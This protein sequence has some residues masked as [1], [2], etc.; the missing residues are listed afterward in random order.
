MLHNF[1]KIAL[2]Q[3]VKNKIYSIT[4][5]TGLT[6]GITF[7]LLVFMVV[8]FE[9][10][11]DGYHKNR[12]CIYRVNTGKPGNVLGKGSQTGLMPALIDEFPEIKKVAVARILHSRVGTQLE[13]N[14]NLSLEK[15]AFFVT[16]SFY[17]MFDATWIAGSPATSLA[18]PG[19]VV[20]TESLA[21][22]YF[23]GQ[24]IDNMIKIDNEYEV[25][26]SGI[27]K[28]PPLN[29]DFPI[30]IAISHATFEQSKHFE[31]GDFNSTYSGYQTYVMLGPENTPE[32]LEA[33]FPAMITKYLGKEA[34]QRFAYALQPLRDIHFN[35]AIGNFNRRTTSRLTL[36]IMALI[37]VLILCI[38]SF[39]FINLSTAQAINRATEVGVRKVMGSTRS[40]LMKQFFSET[41]TFVMAAAGLSL[42]ALSILIPKL[43]DII[44]LPGNALQLYFPDMLLVL[45]MIVVLLTFLSGL[46]PALIMANLRPISTL[47]KK[48]G[49]TTLKAGSLRRG[50]V[51]FQFTVTMIMIISTVVVLFQTHYVLRKPLGF[52]KEAVIALDLPPHAPK[53]EAALR[54]NLLS[55][56]SIRDI[57]FSL[58]TPSATYNR[59]FVHYGHITFEEGIMAELK[60]I[61]TNYLAM[62][63]IQILAGRNLKA[64]DPNSAIL[65][66]ETLMKQIGFN[67][68]NEV[69]GESIEFIGIKGE[70]VGVVQNFHSL[71]LKTAIYPLIFF[72]D[73]SWFHKA[74][75]KIDMAQLASILSLIKQQWHDFFPKTFFQYKFL[76]EDIAS[77]YRQEIKTS[78]LLSLL[79]GVAIFIACLGLFGLAAYDAVQ[80]TKEIGIRKVMGASVHAILFLLSKNYL[81]LILVAFLIAIPVTNYLVS[82]WLQEFAY[83][84][85]LNLWIFVA[86][87]LFVAVTAWLAILGQSFQAAVKNPSETLKYE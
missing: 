48:V 23:D 43:I 35:I 72:R 84:I 45:A 67:D 33:K 69:L 18:N 55:H 76:D 17:E 56:S 27:I 12:D 24:A 86:P 53:V 20:I 2:R 1:L 39:N 77:F 7:A 10:S 57:S 37:G 26:V 63:D 78:R 79:A 58:N 46:Y 52:N 22:K 31:A 25:I 13:V 49:K 4:N 60:S 82:E 21:N 50:L 28:D 40:L 6:L 32:A 30:K 51:L 3:I 66:N 38:A 65:I 42:L 15:N 16:P 80:R 61:D 9:T 41:F 73:Q 62:F 74:S 11:Y 83:K 64:S 8:K 87:G 14:G 85:D 75:I 71:S 81:K 59:E 54:N 44:H 68:P 70:I 5:I 29:T 47:K 19:Q 34:N 36:L